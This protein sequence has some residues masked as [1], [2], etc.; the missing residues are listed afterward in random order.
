MTDRSVSGCHIAGYLPN[1]VDVMRDET[2]G[3]ARNLNVKGS[4][5]AALSV[6]SGAGTRM[7]FASNPWPDESL[8]E[9][10][11]TLARYDSAM[12]RLKNH[13]LPVYARA[14]GLSAAELSETFAAHGKQQYRLSH[15]PETPTSTAGEA[16]SAAAE[17]P[18]TGIG[19][20]ADGSFITILAHR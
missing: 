19:A 3:N 1:D 10:R 11:A 14:L 8:P 5:N 12:T 9:L 2:Y 16:I 17:E 18:L 4:W 7:S 20:H 13:L 15:Y 6:T